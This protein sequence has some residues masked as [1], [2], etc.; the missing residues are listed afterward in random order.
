MH[1]TGQDLHTTAAAYLHIARHSEQDHRA[2]GAWFLYA[3][4]NWRLG[5][6]V[7]T[8][9]ALDHIY[10]ID[11]AHS[12]AHLLEAAKQHGANPATMPP[13]HRTPDIPGHGVAR[14]Q[15]TWT[16]LSQQ[17]GPRTS[18]NGCAARPVSRRCAP[19]TA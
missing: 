9:A 11:P 13:L 14:Y 5:D 2:T 19:K 3:W 1:H 7:R 4:T 18:R 16:R 12:A 10:A 8:G 15:V 17:M 6:S